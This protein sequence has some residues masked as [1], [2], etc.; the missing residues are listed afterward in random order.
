MGF[1]LLCTGCVPVW[2]HKQAVQE[3][4]TKG[5]IKAR[6]IAYNDHC[7]QVVEDINKKLK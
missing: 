7:S 1:L 3:A 5:L 2:T 4:Y 6:K